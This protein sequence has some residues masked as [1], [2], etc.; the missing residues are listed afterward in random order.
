MVARN[1]KV[2]A[3]IGKGVA[4]GLGAALL[5]ATLASRSVP[6]GASAATPGPYSPTGRYGNGALLPN[7]RLVRP[8]GTVTALGD[9]PT[10]IAVSPSKSIAVVVN[11]GQGE[12]NNP[13]QGN[14]SLQVVDL[15]TNAVVQ[16]ITD[17]DPGQDTFYNAGVAFSRDGLH[18]Y[19]SGGGNDAVYDYAVSGKSLALVHHWVSTSKHQPIY[20]SGS[21]SVGYS[22]GLAV[23]ADGGRVYVTNEQGSSLAALR[24][25]DG[26]IA[27]ET[28]LGGAWQGGGY[29]ESV[30]LSPDGTRA[31]V[32]AQG[33][34]ALVAF[35]TTTGTVR[36]TTPVGDHP[37]A[38]AVSGDGS[39]AFVANANDDSLSVLDL[40]QGQPSTVAQ[41]S[42][43][44][45]KGEA[46]G[47][48]PDA[49]VVDDTHRL[50]YVANAGDD[51]VAV[52]GSA[53]PG[54]SHWSPTKLAVLGFLPTAWYPAA[55]ALTSP[56]QSLLV[57]S[58]KGFGGVP[59]VKRTQYDGN[60]MVGT[61]QRAARPTTATLPAATERTRDALTFGTGASALRSAD[62][63]VPD[64]AHAGS[65]PI[66]H[67]VL[68]VR[69]NRTFDQVF[70]DLHSLGRPDANVD[71][72]FL[73]FGQTDAT[74]HTVTPN[75]HALGARFGLSDNFYSDGE[76]SIQGHHWTV[77]GNSTDYTE[78]SWVQYYSNRNHPYD[79]V[80][81]I[82]Y[83]RCGAIF[84]QLAAQGRTFRDFGELVGLNT[85]QTPTVTPAPG[86][87]CPIPGGK[88][89]P[90]AQAARDPAYDNNI[91][92]TSVKD[93]V[94]LAEFKKYYAPLVA[95][96]QVPSFS[97]VLMGNDHTDGLTPG[98]RT[99][100]ALVSINDK[101]VGGLVDY[102]SHTPQW[103]STAVFIVEDDSQDG[104]DHVDGHRN[105][106][107]A[108]SPFVRPG[109]ISHVHASQ[110]GVLHTIELILGLAPMSA[111]TQLAP[112]PYDLF[113][114]T[115]DPSPYTAL[116]PTYDRTSRN[117][118]PT[119]GSAASVPI[120]LSRVDV[121]GP[122]LE[123]QLWEATRLGQPMPPA[124]VAELR[125]RGRVSDNALAA[126]SRGQSCRCQ[127]LRAAPR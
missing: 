115:P 39:L 31:Y 107:I 7:G 83:P 56:D 32:A 23:S 85:A 105:I 44:T 45:L 99:P 94:R 30:A 75:A 38:V 17:H 100:Q 92:L 18:L 8:I 71:P 124:L 33:F 64:E 59:V 74:G 6:A 110:A 50:V 14:E 80:A 79:P 12:G 57:V 95:A 97:Y 76:A 114:S 10:G 96:D 66:K 117:P 15:A 106:L 13:D 120:N 98:A 41:L 103:S 91:T 119:A 102:L 93:T 47:S 53:L 67:V 126:W 108:A 122:V 24:T 121:A 113:Q 35:D 37:V 54:S 43:H 70:G 21:N 3:R 104:L 48:T 62:N 63:P 22:R 36:T 123:A 58:A 116:D 9:L 49:V 25:S 27:W 19:V 111:Y 42:T 20:P 101:A 60:D 40:R 29:P 11:S 46:N 90:Q 86:A 109:A 1:G 69:E 16:T 112:V 87:A 51:S 52:V 34:N 78:K 55:L 118:S 5:I 65:S 81:P 77:E 72:A 26:T 2:F 61:L 89:D 4:A 68:V 84:Q 127:L 82:V 125:A 88:Y 28:Q 73:E